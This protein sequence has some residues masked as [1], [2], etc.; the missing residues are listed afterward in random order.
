MKTI[1]FRTPDGHEFKV[2][3]EENYN[4]TE[5]EAVGLNDNQL[6]FLAD[7]IEH[8]NSTQMFME[9]IAEAMSLISTDIIDTGLNENRKREVLGT[10]IGLGCIYQQLQK[11]ESA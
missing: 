9:S 5:N 11:L 2:K 1:T 10:L 4:F 8:N 7:L 6:C 3:T